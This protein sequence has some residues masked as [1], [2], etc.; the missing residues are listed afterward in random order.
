MMA[1]ISDATWKTLAAHYEPAQLVELLFTVGQ[2]TTLSMLTNA[3]NIRL[4]PH[5]QGLPEGT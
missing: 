2:Y 5:L 4:E 3:L 1:T